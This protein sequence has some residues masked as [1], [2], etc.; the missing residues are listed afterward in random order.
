[1]L[2][3]DVCDR[4]Q[5]VYVQS[6]RT[7]ADPDEKS[8][9]APPSARLTALYSALS[10]VPKPVVQLIDEYLCRPP[11]S[12]LTRALARAIS[13]KLTDNDAATSAQPSQSCPLCE[14]EAVQVEVRSFYSSAQLRAILH[15]MMSDTET[16]PATRE[17]VS[18]VLQRLYDLYLA[19]DRLSPLLKQLMAEDEDALCAVSITA[20]LAKWCTVLLAVPQGYRAEDLVGRRHDGHALLPVDSEPL[21]GLVLHEWRS[22]DTTHSPGADARLSSPKTDARCM[23]S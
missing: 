18:T 3:T 2:T 9:V 19:C 15:E 11:P 1:V 21:C 22:L 5:L 23:C 8:P 6:G 20:P 17:D 7:M 4:P 13:P 10:D 14:S 16:M 12:E